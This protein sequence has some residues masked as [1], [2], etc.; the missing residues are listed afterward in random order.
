M[1]APL[2]PD[3]ERAR[4]Y[5]GTPFLMDIPEYFRFQHTSSKSDSNNAKQ[6]QTEQDTT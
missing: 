1:R 2:D 5:A 4:R 3:E 6:A